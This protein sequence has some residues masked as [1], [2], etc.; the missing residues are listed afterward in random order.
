MSQLAKYKDRKNWEETAR[1]AKLFV[2]EM[3]TAVYRRPRIRV[4]RGSIAR[5]D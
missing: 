3:R 2:Q 5:D 4:S 1:D